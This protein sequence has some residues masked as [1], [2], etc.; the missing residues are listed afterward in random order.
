MNKLLFTASIIIGL[1]TSCSI[2]NNLEEDVIQSME[3]SNRENGIDGIEIESL[4]LNK[5]SENSYSGILVTL[6]YGGKWQYNVE[7]VTEG[8]MFEWQIL[9]EGASVV[10]YNESYSNVDNSNKSTTSDMC[11]L[12]NQEFFD[13]L[14]TVS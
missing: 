8:Q 6:E 13:Y 7:V 3:L 14:A 12:S 10:D 4:T 1:A 2:N 11:D 5:Q 9:D